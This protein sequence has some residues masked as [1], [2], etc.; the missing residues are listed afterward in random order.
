MLTDPISDSLSTLKK[1]EQKGQPACTLKPASKM[2]GNILKA[3]QKEG[4]IGQFEFV[5]DGK[6]GQYTVALIGRIN[7]CKAIK[8]NYSVNWEGFE[9]YEKRYLPAA[10]IGTLLLTTP[11]GV[12]TQE[13]ARKRRTG[14]RLLAYVY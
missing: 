5:D 7:D 10:G 14:G 4:Y 9:K 12:M 8:P 13:E 2:M 3:M 1:A 6:S 11:T